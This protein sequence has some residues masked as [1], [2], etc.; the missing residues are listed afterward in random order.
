MRRAIENNAAPVVRGGWGESARRYND[1]T[2]Q[3]VALAV[4]KRGRSCVICK[5][6]VARPMNLLVLAMPYRKRTLVEHVSVPPSVLAYA[7][8][9]GAKLWVVRLDNAGEC[10]ALELDR[11]ERVGWLRTSN[12]KPEWFVPV[13]RFERVGW[14]DWDYVEETIVLDEQPAERQLPLP[15][16]TA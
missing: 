4:H 1:T 12:G 14:M 13:R 11:V 2:T 6:V 3:Q 9:R 16:V 10:Y 15:G 8:A 5:L 7:R